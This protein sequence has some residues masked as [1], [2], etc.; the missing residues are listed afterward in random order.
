MKISRYCD[1][2]IVI[3]LV[4]V[5][6]A[7]PLF[8]D[9]SLYSVFDLS[10]VAVLLFSSTI[11]MA[12]WLIKTIFDEEFTF[13]HTEINLP[14]LSYLVFTLIAVVFSINPFMSLVGT[15]KRFDGLIETSSYIFIFFSVV[16][17]I[18]SVKR[19][20]ILLNAIVG[21]A[22]AS[23]IYG[24]MQFFGKDPFHWSS[25]TIDR[26]FST[27]GNPVFYSAFLITSLPLSMALYFGCISFSRNLS[28]N[29]SL[30]KDF[31]Y[32]ICTVAIYTIFWHT[33]TRADFVALIIYLP[34]F[35]IFMGKKRIS[36]NRWKVIIIIAIFIVV[37]TF[38][39]IRPQSS[40]FGYFAREISIVSDKS[41]I[42]TGSG[43]EE[44]P[45]A[46]GR[47]FLANRLKG[48]S[49]NRY[50]QFKTAL[51][52]YNE[53]PVLGLGPDTL[54]ILYQKFLAKVYVKLKEDENW[55]RHDRIH[56]DILDNVVGKGA[57]GLTAY[58]W[59]LMAYFWLI[60]KFLNSEKGRE[61]KQEVLSDNRM[62]IDKRLLVVG[63]GI[64]ALGYLIQNEFS[65]GN[66]PIATLF[67]VVLALTVVVIK[68]TFTDSDVSNSII[69]SNSPSVKLD[70]RFTLRKALLSL[71]VI[72]LFSFLLIHFV[73][74][75]RA[76]TFMERGRRYIRNGDLEEGITY[77]EN[78]IYYNPYEINYRDM[79]NNALFKAEN[80]TKD[81]IWLDSV[82][83][84]ANKNL[85]IV[86]QHCLGFFAKGNAYYMLDRNYG[87]DTIDLAIEN[88]RKAIE[89]DPFQ[90]QIYHH[91]AMAC[92]RKGWLD[93]AVESLK[94]A[95]LFA[96]ENVEYI[97]KLSRIY[98][99]QDK[100]KE[101][102]TLFDETARL[103]LEQT[104]SLATAKGLY[105]AKTG[106]AE[107]AYN[108]FVNALEIDSNN[109]HAL[110]N[111]INIGI[112]LKKIEDAIKYLQHA[113]KLKPS[114][115]SYKVNL[116]ELYGQKGMLNE[117][118]EVMNEIMRIEPGMQVEC[119][120]KLGT[121]Y[122][123]HN[124][125]ENAIT[126]FKKIVELEPE[127]AKG[128]NNLGTIYVQK[129]MP[130]DA[131]LMLKKALE[132]EPDSVVF[133][134]NIGQVYLLQGM[135]DELREVIDSIIKLDAD[136]KDAK[137]LL[138]RMEEGEFAK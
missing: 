10:K 24:F 69:E 84:V 100:L 126:C 6:I 33:K 7:L 40:V 49:F 110:N 1:K 38:Y 17:F 79:L 120:D 45:S 46:T 29:K 131:V 137:I 60:W 43:D 133:L 66:T 53:H 75:Y 93:E 35:F 15:Y 89:V 2:I 74:W 23:S 108:E 54:G 95:L 13:P 122:L 106:N 51:K 9:V 61:G 112:R 85:E 129:G 26:I 48:S 19:L 119:L 47:S 42:S 136:N 121:L 8:F 73:L 124:D 76:D 22:V 81:A 109:M 104:A 130:D 72:T 123:N 52:I 113:I 5:V 83:G 64:S 50:Y 25:S 92:I 78:A 3:M 12:A 41:E 135:F 125:F 116:A 67:W 20:N 68:N 114:V 39:C 77:Y 117:T 28:N 99:Q 96:P 62:I 27:F 63:L 111:A 86:P 21:A 31:V 30:K 90:P 44:R 127:N 88:Y 97:N 4:A 134:G 32:G 55:P 107:Y 56:N 11:I 101:L 71:L 118:I 98:L 132:I 82:I 70:S 65:F 102:E 18:N 80:V 91:F 37:G 59:I 16:V 34:I 87:K 138:K 128:Y 103:G 57:L 58:L 115:I 36:A 14:I 94:M 105:F